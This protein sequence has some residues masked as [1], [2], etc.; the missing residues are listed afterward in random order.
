MIR[1]APIRDIRWPLNTGSRSTKYTTFIQCVDGRDPQIY[2]MCCLRLDNTTLKAYPTAQLEVIAVILGEFITNYFAE[3]GS[4]IPIIGQLSINNSVQFLGIPD[5]GGEG[6]LS[7]LYNLQA[8]AE[9]TWWGSGHTSIQNWGG[10]MFGPYSMT[11]V[12]W[13][14]SVN[15]RPSSLLWS[16][17]NAHAARHRVC[18]NLPRR[19]HQDLLKSPSNRRN[20]IVN[21][22]VHCWEDNREGPV[23]QYFCPKF[24]LLV[25]M[26]VS[27]L[28]LM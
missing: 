8:P 19:R 21:P 22:R 6:G 10:S 25:F 12:A 16:L 28:L 20:F 15:P 4:R 5:H 18:D 26:N 9:A 13:G 23:T 27:F 1:R 3:N 17:S 14:A 2:K 7:F 11:N 24:P